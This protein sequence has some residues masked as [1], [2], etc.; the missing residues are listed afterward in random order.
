VKSASKIFLTADSP[1]HIGGT[2]V[3]RSPN[4]ITKIR[5][6]GQTLWFSP[7]RWPFDRKFRISCSFDGGFGQRFRLF[8][9][10]FMSRE[11]SK[12]KTGLRGAP[13]R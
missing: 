5:R 4:D 2:E 3:Q 11:F 9:P 10:E 13:A 1:Q 7:V 6:M 8:P 12:A